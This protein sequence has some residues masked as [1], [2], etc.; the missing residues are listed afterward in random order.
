M[1]RGLV[2]LVE[3]DP[4]A[5]AAGGAPARQEIARVADVWS[6]DPVPVV[7]VRVRSH[8]PSAAGTG[9]TPDQVSSAL[10]EVV[11]RALTGKSRPSGLYLSG[12]AVARATLDRLGAVAVAVEGE[13]L[14][15]AAFGRI[16]GGPFTG[17]RIVTKGGMIGGEDAVARCLEAVR[18]EA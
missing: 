9:P 16:V 17:L 10:A 4:A 15:L 14:P 7:G 1:A 2:S 18:R 13:V 11:V 5:I 6:A 8:D 3:L 12:G